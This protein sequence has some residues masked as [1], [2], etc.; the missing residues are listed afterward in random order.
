VRGFSFP[1]KEYNMRHP[2]TEKL[3]FYPTSNPVADLL[4]TYFVPA[5]SGRLLDPCAGEGIAAAI[6][7]NALNCASWGAE[8]SP[9]RAA[10]AAEQMDRVFNAP[11]QSCH[12]TSESITLLFLNPPYSHD[13][14]GDQK[15]LELEFLKSTTPKLVRGGA[16]VYIVP[17]ALLRDNDVAT[18]LAGYYEH[19]TVFRYPETAF[20][21]VIVLGLKRQKYKMPSAEEIG[22]VQAWAEVEPPMLVDAAQPMY[23]LLPAPDKGAGGQAV[24]FSRL[25]WQPEEVVDSTRKR[26]LHTTKEWLDL[27]NPERALGAFKQPVMPLK[28]G[29]IA[30]LMASGMMGT[31]RLNDDD[32]KPML[33]KGRVVKVQEKVDES[34]SKDGKSVTETFRDRFVSTV[35]VVRQ[36]GIEVIDQVEP[37]SKFMHKYGDQL[38]AHILSTYRPLYNFDPTPQE[39]AILDTL[40]TKRKPLPG[41]EKAGLLPT[42]RHVA[43]A[44]ARTIRKHGVGNIQGE[45]GSGKAQPLSVKIYTP[46]GYKLM[47]DILVGDQVINPEGGYASVIGVYPQGKTDIY[48]VTFSDGS[49]T[50]CTA[51][52]LWE[53]YSP[54]RKWKGKPKYVKPL[55][56]I[57]DE[58]LTH[59]NS[60]NQQVFIPMVK[61]VEFQKRSLPVH[62]YLVGVLLGDGGLSTNSIILTTADDEL[63]DYI[64]EYLP[65]P[66]KLKPSGNK[67]GWRLSVGRKETRNP[68]LDS[69]R[70]MGL[71]GHRSYDKFIPDDYLYSDSADRLALLQGLLDTDGT[72]ANSIAADYLTTSLELAK[73]VN[74]SFR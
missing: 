51:E 69:F 52:H 45:M 31:L 59:S 20:N 39:T 57:M 13:R 27:L 10:L 67:Y 30:M 47:G 48:R 71:M 28:K 4:K 1:Y 43:A 17:H 16:L 70:D 50:K 9:A 58:P 72:V 42:Q 35:A 29:H 63:L 25:D 22:Q 56:Q 49:A 74:F 60:G 11:W 8:L 66:V 38:G 62:P 14:L 53:V 18:H 65:H 68:L 64:R 33:V 41:Q 3:G 37:L 21:Q 7:A 46:D 5:D 34:T 15:R 73:G 2:A 44:V 54:L 26:G 32:G 61:P 40:G 36:A 6:L 23:Q 24:R 12:L 19:L 55:Y